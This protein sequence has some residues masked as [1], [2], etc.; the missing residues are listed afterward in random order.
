M[1]DSQGSHLGVPPQSAVADTDNDMTARALVLDG[2]F[3]FCMEAIIA[4]DFNGLVLDINVPAEQMLGWLRRQAVGKSLMDFIS[5]TGVSPECASDQASFKNLTET[6]MREQRRVE[7]MI[8][9]RDGTLFPGEISLGKGQ[10]VGFAYYSCL[11]LDISRQRAA[12]LHLKRE[13]QFSAAMTALALRM[14]H[15][16]PLEQVLSGALELLRQQYPTLTLAYYGIP[17]GQR[18]G[19]CGACVASEGR[20][21][22]HGQ[23]ELPTRLEAGVPAQLLAELQRQWPAAAQQAVWHWLPVQNENQLLGYLLVCVSTGPTPLAPIQLETLVQALA[24]GIKRKQD[25]RELR[26]LQ[27]AID[28]A[29]EGIALLDAQEKFVYLNPAYAR[30]HGYDSSAELVG[31]TYHLLYCPA[32]IARLEQEV[33]PQLEKTGHWRGSLTGV[34]KDGTDIPKEVDLTV[35]PDGGLLCLCVDNSERLNAME[36]LRTANAA[37]QR[38]A[39]FKDEVLANMSHELRTPLNAIIGMGECLQLGTYGEVNERQGRSVQ[40]ILSSARHLAELIGDILDLAKIE[41]GKLTPQK[42]LLDVQRVTELVAAMFRERVAT[43]R[44]S[45]VV[46]VPEGLPPLYT[47]ER[48]LK[49]IL[50]N[51]LDN[52]IKFT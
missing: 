22:P 52:A 37:L 6:A 11:V 1:L 47:D 43:K 13:L 10:M 17:P 24:L 2:A 46:Q 15:A 44:Q 8:R 16:G 39:R 49:Q 19:A 33:R 34:K 23:A 32:V 48:R 30:L 40:T 41:A 20:S 51:L 18:C 25:H 29:F 27:L 45:L 21:Q 14:N 36:S 3:P 12:E 4:V 26:R 5:L 38:S 42:H 50:V 7:V 35:L 31:R 28:S 9:R